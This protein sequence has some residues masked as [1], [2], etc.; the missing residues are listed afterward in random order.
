MQ[1]P[2]PDRESPN[3]LAVKKQAWEEFAPVQGVEGVGL[4]DKR[5]RVYVRNAEVG[6]QIPATYHGV[7][8]D[9]IVVGQI[10]LA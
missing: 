4:G 5:L 3:L 6:R 1:K 8:V 10:A 2:S 7:E 9:V